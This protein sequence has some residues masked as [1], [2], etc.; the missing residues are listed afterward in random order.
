MP[1]WRSDIGHFLLHFAT[2]CGACSSP[3][4]A[5]EGLMAFF[6][7]SAVS[8]SLIPGATRSKA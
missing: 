8:S 2:S 7:A 6:L 1:V 5:Y 4:L 3:L